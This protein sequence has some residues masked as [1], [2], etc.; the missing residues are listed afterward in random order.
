MC[1]SLTETI[2]VQYLSYKVSIM[3]ISLTETILVQY[4][5]YKVSIM[6]IFNHM[7]K[8]G[9]QSQFLYIT[10]LIYVP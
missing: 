6:C 8:N 10:E 3:C 2:L 1:I 4:L 7:H 9:G 5:S